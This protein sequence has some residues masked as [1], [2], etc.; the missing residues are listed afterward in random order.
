MNGKKRR[1]THPVEGEIASLNSEPDQ[2]PSQPAEEGGDPEAADE[3]LKALP[4]DS[5]LVRAKKL[6][7]RLDHSQAFQELLKKK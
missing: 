7:K 2:K 5:L 4:E 6:Q 3:S 1:I